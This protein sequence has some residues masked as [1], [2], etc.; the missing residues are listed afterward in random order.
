METENCKYCNK[1]VTIKTKS[2]LS[3]HLAQC[4]VWK[5]YLKDTEKKLTK[6][7]LLK[8][9]IELGK[10]ASELTKILG[11]KKNTLIFKKLREF[12]IKERDS[13]ERVNMPRKLEKAKK[14]SLE[15]YG[16]EWHLNK[17]CKIIRDKID[18]TVKE[19]YNCDNIFQAKEIKDKIK[20][21]CLE[22]HGVEYSG[23]SEQRKQRVKETCL[24]R[25]GVD[26]VWKHQAVIQKCKDTKASKTDVY[27]PLSKMSQ[28]LFWE[29]YNELEDRDHIYFG[30]LNK[31]FGKRHFRGYYY[32][33]FVDTKRKKCIEFN[34]NYY[35]AN[36][37][38]YESEYYNKRMKMH[39]KE[40]WNK[41]SV[42]N[43][44]IKD[45]GFDLLIIWE[46]ELKESKDLVL[47]KMRNFLCQV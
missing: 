35:H 34:G 31:E 28:E 40:I 44:F 15:R 29:L 9:Y 3:G 43:N 11:L 14:T 24:A 6:E 36:P 21:T 10:S 47:S 19:K 32:Y 41:D 1:E 13:K 42:K 8:E 30:E 46:S 4:K 39:A 33:D 12:N 16:S 45:K 20:E 22:R 5:Q 27:T 18:Y 25:Y 7:F 2:S 26:N 37:L 17:E 38:M 23:Q